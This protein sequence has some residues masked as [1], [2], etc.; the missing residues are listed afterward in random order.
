MGLLF[1]R[2]LSCYG[3]SGFF[4]GLNTFNNDFADFGREVG[5]IPPIV[6][7]R[8]RTTVQVGSGDTTVIGGIFESEQSSASN[9]VPALHRIPILGWLFKSQA[10]R[11]ST[12]ELLIFLTPRI[13]R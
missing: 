10:D 7:Q 3:S 8:A 13:V 11:E 6:T 5:G 4:T 1:L 9:R 12:D 2:R